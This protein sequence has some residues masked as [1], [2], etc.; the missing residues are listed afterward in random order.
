MWH[1]EGTWGLSLLFP[2]KFVA[3]SEGNIV[4]QQN[5]FVLFLLA[6]ETLCMSELH[7]FSRMV[8]IN[9]HKLFE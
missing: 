6:K 7:Q 1:V 2:C 3:H 5:S 9:S 4:L 8:I